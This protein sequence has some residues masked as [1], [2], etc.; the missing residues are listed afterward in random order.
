MKFGRNSNLRLSNKCSV[1]EA[2]LAFFNIV[3]GYFET[4]LIFPQN[5]VD[6][7]VLK[8]GHLHVTLYTSVI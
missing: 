5:Y 2:D 7:L 3:R 6:I 4:F 8:L 1:F